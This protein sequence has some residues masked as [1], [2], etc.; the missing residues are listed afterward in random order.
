M[1]CSAQPSL[2]EPKR[3]I[4]TPPPSALAT[5]DPRGYAASSLMI[6]RD[7]VALAN[8]KSVFTLGI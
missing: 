2:G 7:R 6:G 8:F 3:Y 5:N 1:P 4:N